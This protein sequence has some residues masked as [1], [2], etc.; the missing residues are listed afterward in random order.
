MPAC[1]IYL[2][3]VKKE[4][5]RTLILRVEMT[6]GLKAAVSF[7]AAL[8][9]EAFFA[10]SIVC[11]RLSSATLSVAGAGLNNDTRV[12]F[13]KIKTNFHSTVSMGIT[14]LSKHYA[15]EGSS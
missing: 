4:T 9:G 11:L 13:W 14:R 8:F 10:D 7:P 3:D 2:N 12:A 5:H 15:A 1:T 6:D